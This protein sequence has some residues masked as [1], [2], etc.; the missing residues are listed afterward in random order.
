MFLSQD[1]FQLFDKVGDD[2]VDGV[3][4]IKLLQ[5]VGLNPL[6]EDVNKVLK[7]SG[8]DT[9]RLDFPTF[10]SIYDQFEKRPCLANHADLMEMFKVFNTCFI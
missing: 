3:D 4:V 7:D 9:Q 8:L 1:A 2:K 10:V 5:S 6:T